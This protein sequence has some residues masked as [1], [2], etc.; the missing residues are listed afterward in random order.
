MVKGKNQEKKRAMVDGK[1]H[2]WRRRMVAG[3]NHLTR[4]DLRFASPLLLT[5]FAL[6]TTM[7]YQ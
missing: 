4:M 5:V 2:L 6:W 1:N 3:K 7:F